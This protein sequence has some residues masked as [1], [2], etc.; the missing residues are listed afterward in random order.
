MKRVEADKLFNEDKITK[1]TTSFFYKRNLND[2]IDGRVSYQHKEKNLQMMNEE[3]GKL[4]KNVF[5]HKEEKGVSFKVFKDKY[6]D[7]PKEDGDIYGPIDYEN[8]NTPDKM[9]GQIRYLT[10]FEWCS[11]EIIDQFMHMVEAVHVGITGELLFKSE[12]R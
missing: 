5:V 1:E 3:K 11:G 8:C 12:G 7:E 4:K 2:L 10:G 6:T 9:L